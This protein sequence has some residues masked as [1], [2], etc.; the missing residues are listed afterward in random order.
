MPKEALYCKLIFMLKCLSLILGKGRFSLRMMGDEPVF[1]LH[2]VLGLR[3]K[4][5]VN[6]K[7]LAT[8]S[9]RRY[10]I[11]RNSIIKLEVKPK[12]PL[13]PDATIELRLYHQESPSTPIKACERHRD[14]SGPMGAVLKV[15]PEG[16]ELVITT[17]ATDG[18]I[19]HRV[20][21][22]ATNLNISFNCASSDYTY[23]ETSRRDWILQ[24]VVFP[25]GRTAYGARCGVQVYSSLQ[26]RDTLGKRKLN[27]Q[28]ASEITDYPGP[29]PK[30][31]YWEQKSEGG[32]PNWVQVP[33]KEPE[34][35]LER[36]ELVNRF[37]LLELS[38]QRLAL[39]ILN[40]V[41]THRDL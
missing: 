4:K 39:D 6:L 17:L 25:G 32:F 3:T 19:Y 15:V 10:H 23:S 22:T 31:F 5:K 26:K 9:G 21:G 36:Q 12:Q 16:G 28:A 7:T 41:K 20:P 14:A 18:T 13:G 30:T 11:Q 40:L 35:N 2:E 29:G 33:E 37:L 8:E 34:P 1:T 38:D 24:L 27:K